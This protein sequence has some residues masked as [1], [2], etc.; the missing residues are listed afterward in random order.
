MF[1]WMK[2]TPLGASTDA[3]KSVSAP[4][5]AP[6]PEYVPDGIYRMELKGLVIKDGTARKCYVVTESSNALIPVGA[7]YS[8]VVGPSPVLDWK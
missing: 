7:E 3:T 5:P 1:E 8:E 4:K 2:R 6:R